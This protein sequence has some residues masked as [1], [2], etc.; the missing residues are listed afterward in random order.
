MRRADLPGHRHADVRGAGA[1]RRQS[2][3]D[4]AADQGGRGGGNTAREAAAELRGF[5]HRR[6][7]RR[8]PGTGHPDHPL[9]AVG[10]RRHRDQADPEGRRLREHERAILA[11][12]DP[13]SSRARRS[14]AR[15]RPQ[16]YSPR[17]LEGAREGLQSGRRGRLHRRRPDVGVSAREGTALPHARRR[18]YR[19]ATGGSGSLDHGDRQ[20]AHRR[21]HGVRRKDIAHRLQDLG[22]QS[23]ARQ[24]LRVDRVRLLGISPAGGPAGPAHRRDRVLAVP[25]RRHRVGPDV[26]RRRGRRWISTHGSRGAI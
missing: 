25:R 5:D 22:A 20:R 1:G 19:S 4:E 24:L 9:R 18:E 23:T 6:E 11:S 7:L 16:M 10:A 12:R 2:D 17:G 21:T 14:D 26:V 8:Q 13:R 3:L 15:R